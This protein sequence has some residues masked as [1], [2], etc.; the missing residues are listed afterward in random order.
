[1]RICD[2]NRSLHVQYMLYHLILGVNYMHGAGIIHRDLKPANV[3]INADCSIKICDFGLARGFSEDIQADK[4]E[5]KKQRKKRGIF[6]HIL[7]F[8]TQ[9]ID[10]K[11]FKTKKVSKED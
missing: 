9:K 8:E 10:L 4:K 7:L 2:I 5:A 3:L 1:M 11:I 6:M